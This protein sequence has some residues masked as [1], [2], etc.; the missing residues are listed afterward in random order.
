LRLSVFAPLVLLALGPYTAQ[1]QPP[2]PP[3]PPQAGQP[4]RD[5]V[6]R[7]PPD[8]TGTA[9]IRGRVVAG[10]TGSPIRKANVNLSPVMPLAVMQS[11]AG[12]GAGA[13]PAQMVR[14]TVVV[15]G[16]PVQVTTSV[17]A[18]MMRPRS[19]VTD[20]QGMFEFKDLPAG[21]YRLSAN[22]SQYSAQ[23]IGATYGAKR[24]N[25]P[26]SSDPGQ[27]IPLTDGQAFTATVALFKGSVIMGHVGDENGDPL[28]RV[29]VYPL[30]FPVGSTRGQRY[31][32]TVTTDDLGNFRLYGLAPGEYVVVAEARGNNYAPPNAP[33]ETE[34]ERIGMLT[35][36]YPG[37]ADEGSAQRVRT[38]TG[39][40]TPGIEIRM[41]TGRMLHISG[42]VVDSQGKSDTRFSVQLM[43]RTGN[44][45]SNFGINMD[46]TGHFMARNIP[47]G[48][49][50]L[51]AR[52][53]INRPPN[54][55]PNAPFDQGE[56]AVVPISLTTSDIDDL[57]LTTNAGATITGQIVYENGP[58]PPLPSGAPAQPPRINAQSPDPQNFGGLPTPQGVQAS[59]DLTFTMKGFMGEYLIRANGGTQYMKS[60]QL[61]GEDITDTPHEFKPG[62]KLTI[63]MTTRASTIEGT[64]SDDKGE[65]ANAGTLLLFSED[66][67]SWRINSVHTRR[68]GVDIT[69]HFRMPGV[70]PGRYLLIAL[71]QERA[72]ALNFGAG[73]P[74][75]FEQFAKEATSV[76]V[77]EDEQRQVD[78][79]ISAGSGGLFQ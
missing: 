12:Q 58:P 24:A 2:P 75:M 3:P 22:P 55:P 70:L 11:Q 27:P 68:S 16:N 5:P 37:T 28:A 35:T 53:I 32:P 65:P 25:S 33:P 17:Q 78:L 64:V 13:P 62:D 18:G 14:Q 4:A 19:A 61:G 56:F 31:G 54:T 72:N 39:A 23:Y 46:Q 47:P 42:M 49:Y 74:A 10:D 34:E 7:P 15:N 69:G 48:D 50:K 8:P 59:A 30:F 67:T 36:Y 20:A 38:R 26:G 66:K 45:F 41:L 52:Q 29:Q 79:K 51:I 77:G 60:V 1:L 40:E 76:T 9:S 73:D 43:Q 63:V 44:S 6:R 71:P 57:L 21:T